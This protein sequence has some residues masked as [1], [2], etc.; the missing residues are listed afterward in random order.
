MNNY[1]PIIPIAFFFYLFIIVTAYLQRAHM[2]PFLLEKR[3]FFVSLCCYDRP[4][5]DNNYE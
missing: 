5:L 3:R 4:I 2:N 1:S